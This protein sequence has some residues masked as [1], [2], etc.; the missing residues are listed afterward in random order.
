[1]IKDISPVIVMVFGFGLVSLIGV[2]LYRFMKSRFKR[3]KF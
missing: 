3:N 2:G 1:M